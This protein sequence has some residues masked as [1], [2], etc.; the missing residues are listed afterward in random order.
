MRW[1]MRTL[2]PTS[3]ASNSNSSTI[4]PCRTGRPR[5]RPA[6]AGAAPRA[7]ASGGTFE[8]PQAGEHPQLLHRRPHRPRQEHARRPPARAD[9]HADAA[10]DEGAGPGPVSYTHLTLPTSDL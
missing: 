9:A 4:R 10:A 2:T 6:A 7:W 8:R 3:A 5:P 1:S